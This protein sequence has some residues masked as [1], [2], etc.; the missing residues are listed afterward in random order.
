[1]K[2]INKSFLAIKLTSVSLF[3]GISYGAEAPKF[4]VLVNHIL[5][6]DTKAIAEMKKEDVMEVLDYLE[7]DETP[8]V[9][10]K[11]KKVSLENYEKELI[12][13]DSSEAYINAVK[14]IIAEKNI[15]TDKQTKNLKG[16]ALYYRNSINKFY[17]CKANYD[18]AIK[19]L[20]DKESDVGDVIDDLKIKRSDCSNT[21]RNSLYDNEHKATFRALV[22]TKEKW[23][24]E[25]NNPFELESMLE[26]NL[27]G[28]SH[29]ENGEAGYLMNKLLSKIFTSHINDLNNKRSFYEAILNGPNK[30]V[31]KVVCNVKS[32]AFSGQPKASYNSKE[33]TLN[34]TGVVEVKDALSIFGRR[35]EHH[36]PTNDQVMDVMNAELAKN[37]ISK[38]IEKKDVSILPIND[39]K[40]SKK[41][42]VDYPDTNSDN[43]KAI[44]K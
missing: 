20:S 9:V 5:E 32:G 34:L 8:S 26:L 6:K 17:G 1:M 15:E 29:K 16:A 36:V 11:W 24:D 4:N 41:N 18:S 35:K 38:S 21:F 2:F 40:K 39:D 25:K 14:K 44:S 10:N 27:V 7:K 13:P 23:L 22:E 28:C 19:A 42:M 33:H 43:V 12:R 3:I 30:Q 37:I 31:L